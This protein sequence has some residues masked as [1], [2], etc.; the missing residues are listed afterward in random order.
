MGNTRD[1]SEFS[2]SEKKIAGYL[3]L[4]IHTNKDHTFKLKQP[5]T[6][7]L[8][9]ENGLVFLIDKQFNIAMLKD[10]YLEDWLICAGCGAEGF[11]SD[12]EISP[13]ICCRGCVQNGLRAA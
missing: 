12:L 6:L 9:P 4:A 1:I 11:A 10:G 2:E 5:F 7:E 13:K 8:N 3:L